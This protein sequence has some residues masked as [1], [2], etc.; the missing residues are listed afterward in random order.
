MLH[1][2]IHVFIGH[3]YQHMEENA[4]NSMGHLVVYEV[5]LTIGLAGVI[6]LEGEV[7]SYIAAMIGKG[8][9]IT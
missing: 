2:F 3:E 9:N 5:L 1:T 4:L 7:S 8:Y 6:Y